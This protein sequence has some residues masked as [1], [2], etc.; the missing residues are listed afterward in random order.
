MVMENM[1]GDILSDQCGGLLGS[2]PDAFRMYRPE[3]VPT[4]SHPMVCADIAGK[5]AL[6]P[7]Q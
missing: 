3:E 5:T 2:W 1:F 4:M 6:H 7:T